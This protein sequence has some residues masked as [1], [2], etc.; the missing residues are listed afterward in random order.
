MLI[1]LCNRFRQLFGCR[2]VPFVFHCEVCRYLL[3]CPF[4]LLS[5]KT[6]GSDNIKC[7]FSW[8]FGNLNRMVKKW[9][10]Y[11]TIIWFIIQNI[12]ISLNFS[13]ITSRA[14]SRNSTMH[15]QPPLVE[16]KIFYSYWTTMSPWSLLHVAVKT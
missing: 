5:V 4:C 11:F 9:T 6:G 8:M 12:D 16:D 3:Y 15:F 10:Q 2:R 13:M 7:S 1:L 14:N